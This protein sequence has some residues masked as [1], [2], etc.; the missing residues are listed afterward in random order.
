MIGSDEFVFLHGPFLGGHVSFRGFTL[1]KHLTLPVRLHLPKRE[2]GEF[3]FHSTFCSNGLIVND[4][5]KIHHSTTFE[6]LGQGDYQES[7]QNRSRTTKY[8]KILNSLYPRIVY[9]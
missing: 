6:N 8:N 2:N 4:E 7:L 5:M 9:M 3:R 1:R